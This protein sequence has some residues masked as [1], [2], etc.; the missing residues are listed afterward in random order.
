MRRARVIAAGLT[1]DDID[2]MIKQAQQEV[3]PS[4]DQGLTTFSLQSINPRRF[5]LSN[6]TNGADN[7]R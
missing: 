2:R 7:E 5:A 1:D 6:R 3:A 4:V